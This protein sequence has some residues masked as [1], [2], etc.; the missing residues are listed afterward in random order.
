MAICF[1]DAK[2]LWR[3]RWSGS[4]FSELMTVGHLSLF[5]HPQEVRELKAEFKI[6]IPA[7]PKAPLLR[8]K[9]GDYSDEF[10]TQFLGVNTL[11]ILDVSAYEGATI[12]HDLNQP[13]PE[14]FWEKYTAVI[15][16]G[17]LEHVFNF[18]V[19]IENMMRLARVGGSLFITTP[20]NN[21]CGH[22]FY[23]FSPELMFRVFTAGNGFELKDLFLFEARF[24]SVELTANHRVFQVFDPE[25]VQDRVG[26]LSK[27]PIM[28]MVHAIKKKAVKPFS[29]WPLQS[30]YR[31]LWSSIDAE[32]P[33][34]RNPS[35]LRNI[36]N[37]LPFSL[38]VKIKGYREA[39]KFSFSNRQSFK[40]AHL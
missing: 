37:R 5:L 39:R 22:G 26:V 18:P 12:I 1:N 2:L 30:D 35:V 14:S 34:N 9:F 27:G 19:A 28:M 13:L 17:S 23:Q 8:Y 40:R 32:E 20:C 6:K 11:D 29:N 7:A 21:L 16:C 33:S 3:A 31:P 25:Q 10:L 24:P 4:D 36:F 15:D 38:Q